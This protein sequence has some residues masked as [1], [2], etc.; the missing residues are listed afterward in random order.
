MQSIKQNCSNGWACHRW[1]LGLHPELPPGVA[2]PRKVGLGFVEASLLFQAAPTL[3]VSRRLVLRRMPTKVCVNKLKRE[4]R[5]FISAPPPHIPAIHVN[6]RNLLG[7]QC[8][9]LCPGVLYCIVKENYETVASCT[10]WHFLIEGPPDTPYT[11][12]P[13]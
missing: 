7:T 6:E 12:M 9:Q 4:M 3:L 1:Y 10:E 2:H 5:D 13:T 8:L 11:G